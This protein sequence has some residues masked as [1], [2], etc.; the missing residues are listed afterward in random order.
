MAGSAAR[1]SSASAAVRI[2]GGASRIASGWTGVDEE[3]GSR[4]AVATAADAA[5]VSTTPSQQAAAAHPRDSGWLDA[6][7]CRR[8]AARR[9]RGR[10]PSMPSRSMC[11]APPA[12]P[13]RRPGCR[14]RCEPWSPAANAVPAPRPMQA[15][16]GRPPPRPLASVMTSGT[17]PSAWCRR[18]TR[19][20]GRCRSG[21]RRAPAARRAAVR[22][23]GPP[24]V[25]GRGRDDAALA[26]DRL[27]DDRRRS[28]STA[29]SARRRRRRARS[30]R[31]AAAARTG[32]RIAGLPVSAS[33]PMVRPWKPPSVATILGAAGAA[34][35]TA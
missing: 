24:Q 28:S 7:R 21:P 30:R 13:R 12:P 3:A 16:I 25:A 22:P 31:R 27:E 11:R 2:S 35:A 1:N 14:R 29:A 8:A 19:R 34:C 6:P 10:W 9:P 5:P 26:L 32:S 20:C 18:T 17:T 33:A 15:P 23:R 4:A